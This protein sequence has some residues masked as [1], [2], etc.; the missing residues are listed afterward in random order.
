MFAVLPVS[1]KAQG[2]ADLARRDV[3][4]SCYSTY[5]GVEFPGHASCAICVAPLSRPVTK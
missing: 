2:L 1:G 4:S 5:V 3:W